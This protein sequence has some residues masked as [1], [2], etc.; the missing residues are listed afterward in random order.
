M[1]ALHPPQIGSSYWSVQFWDLGLNA[2]I[3]TFSSLY[4]TKL[5]KVAIS[6]A[7]SLETARPAD[8]LGFDH[9]HEAVH[10][11]TKFQHSRAMHGRV[12]VTVARFFSG[13]WASSPGRIWELHG[14]SQM[15]EEN[16]PII[17]A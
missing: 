14:P 4:K 2:V 11:P 8:F 17:G 12:T 9:Y 1:I 15:W 6:A 16:G 13:R 7:L 5:E 10:Q 3:A